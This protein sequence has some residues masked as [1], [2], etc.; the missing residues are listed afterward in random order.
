MTD[1][2]RE[3]FYERQEKLMHSDCQDC[4]FWKI[5]HG[6]C[7]LD[8]YDDQAKNFDRKTFWCQMK[9]TFLEKYFE[10]ITGY[11]F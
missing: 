11:T 2:K 10:P 6:G 7:P 8:A 3:M 4:R 9:T 1:P 5:C